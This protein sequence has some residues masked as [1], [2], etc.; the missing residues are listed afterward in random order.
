MNI[1]MVD[2]VTQYRKIK[3]EVD[4][5]IHRVLD[6]GH[7]IMGKEVGEFEAAVASYLNVK[8]A[9]GCASGTDGL[10]VAMMALG[11]GH[12]DEV[13]TTPFTFVAT[14]ETIALIGA[15][16]VYV[17]IDPRTYN[18]D[19]AKIEA[20]ITKRTKAIIPVHLYGQPCD[21]DAIMGIANKHGIPVIEDAAQAMGAEYTGRKVGGIG[22][23]G[24]ISFFPSKNLGAFGDAGMVVTNDPLL[25]EKARMIIVHGSRKK[26]YHEILGVNSR[27]DTL[28]AAIL[29]VKLKYLEEWHE[30]RRRAAHAYNRLFARSGIIVPSE[31]PGCKHIYHQYTLRLSRRDAVAKHLA[32]KKIPHAIYYPIPLHLQ[33][34]FTDPVVPEG[35]FPVTERAAREVLSLPMH[36][37]LSE[38]QQEFIVASVREAMSHAAGQGE[39]AGVGSAT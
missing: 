3:P 27:L 37:E 13:V 9:V 25:A 36:T 16:P 8:Y 15:R 20:A 29:Q 33:Q 7:Y 34:A 18:I 35:T 4:E 1:Q 11:I 2:L 39:P 19:P 6:S 32:D 14:A 30:A 22:A 12:G 28:Q 5:A 23:F 26:Y 24:A 31:A 21:M 10:Q 38:E 17:D